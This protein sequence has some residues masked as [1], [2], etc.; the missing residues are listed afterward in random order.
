MSS[1]TPI[2]YMAM[3]AVLVALGYYFF[4]IP[5]SLKH[6]QTTS[7]VPTTDYYCPDSK[8]VDAFGS[9]WSDEFWESNPDATIED[10]TIEWNR[11][12]RA[13]KC[14][15]YVRTPEEAQRTLDMR[16]KLP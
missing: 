11:I 14:S 12:A 8:Y 10:W 6:K 3:L 13:M 15:I 7:A 4:Y 1:I 5:D 9:R 16:G 2:K